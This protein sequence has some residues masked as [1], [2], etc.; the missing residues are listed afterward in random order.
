MEG[1]YSQPPTPDPVAGIAQG[2]DSLNV[3]EPRTGRQKR[4]ARAYHNLNSQPEAH[5][6]GTQVVPGYGAGIQPAGSQFAPDLRAGSPMQQAQQPQ[7]QSPAGYPQQFQQQQQQFS[8]FGQPQQAGGAFQPAAQPGVQPGGQFSTRNFSQ[9][10]PQGHVTYAGADGI[11][12]LNLERATAGDKLPPDHF[13]KTFENAC[14]PGA[15][16]DYNVAD[17]GLSG[18]QYARLTMYNVPTTENL[19]ASTKLPLGLLLRP[20]APFSNKEYESGG[21]AVADFSQ[22]IPPPRCTRCRTY[23]N[24]SMMFDQGGTSFVCNMC[25]FSNPVSAEYFQPVDSSGRRIDW[26]QRPE[27]AFGTYDIAVPSEYWKDPE[28]PPS[29]LHYLFI[30]DVTQDSVKRGLHLA[31]IKAIKNAIYGTGIDIGADAQAAAQQFAEKDESGNPIPSP[32][33]PIQFPKGAKVG[34]ATFDRTVHFYNI[35]PKLEQPQVHV[36]GDITD[37][38]V[39]L[40]EGLFVDPEESQ[41]L[42]DT[43]FEMIGGMYSDSTLTEP[44][45]GVALELAYQALEKTGGKVSVILGSLP[46]YGLGAV[47]I[48]NTNTNPNY[49]GEKEKDLYIVDNK[50][51]KDMGKKLALA[52]IGVDLFVFPTTLVELSN[53]GAAS[54]MSGG[55]EFY[56]PRYVPERDE[57][58][59]VAELTRSVQQEIGTQVSFKVRC[60]TGLQVGAYFGNFFHEEWDQD[61]SMGSIDSRST[62]GVLFK[63]DGKLDPKL[64]VHFQSALLYTSNTGQKRVRVNNV[65]ASVTTDY[66]AVMSFV[67]ADAC[68]GIITRENLSRMGEF[69]P[70]ELRARLNDRLIDVF[71]SYRQRVTS[72]LPSSQLLMPMS[73]RTFIPYILSLQKSRPFRDQNLTSDM[74]VHGSRLMNTMFADELSPYLYPRI[75]GLHNLRETDCTYDATGK[76][77]YPASIAA[78]VDDIEAG[79]VY[80]VYNGV[81]LLLWIHRQVAPALLVDLFGEEVDALDRL[82]PVL[83]VLPEIDTEVSIKARRLIKYLAN[84]SGLEFLGFQIA[85][86]SLDGSDYELQLA[87]VEDPGTETYRYR[88]YVTFIH[89]RVKSKLDSSNEKSTMSYL[90][91]HFSFSSGS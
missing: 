83:N 65:I 43:L 37:P 40:E 72:G 23:M 10:A 82:N 1:Y 50:F 90:S 91:G 62:L 78:T 7:F 25:Q 81:S 58:Q 61:P 60:S 26:H 12:R 75:M 3:S 80:I 52:G 2:V 55:H 42:I 87:L 20:F 57:S 76:F 56:Y 11:P 77:I 17:Q 39:P 64:D 41:S 88:D 66:S 29:P 8:Q 22:E 16:A 84:R 33:H 89:N 73:L 48:R 31:A 49:Q 19:R 54:Q 14:P 24:P 13:F 70:K 5:P 18:P 45:Y 15:G 30:I 44:V 36:M 32:S 79:G 67:D 74:R 34:I 59:F 28:V 38:F 21:V 46:S 63:H 35:S 85:R 51:H 71:S 47:A 86:Q 53:V 4:P 9:S 69:P 27:L 6:Y 68:V